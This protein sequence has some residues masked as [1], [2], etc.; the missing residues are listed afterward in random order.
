MG[1]PRTGDEETVAKMGHPVVRGGFYG[2][3]EE[4]AEKIDFG[5]EDSLGD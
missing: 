2:T 5:R 1:H 3:R 4:G